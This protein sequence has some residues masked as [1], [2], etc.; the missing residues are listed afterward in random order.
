MK[1]FLKNWGWAI[2][3]VMIPLCLMA[4]KWMF[5]TRDE[6]VPV[7]E[8]AAK[9][10]QAFEYHVSDRSGIHQS[11]EQK[12]KAFVPRLELTPILVEIKQDQKS[13]NEKLDRVLEELRKR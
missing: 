6:F 2:P 8:E 11:Y 9:T 3:T 5:V 12:S 13:T 4:A 7:K 10:A 1:D